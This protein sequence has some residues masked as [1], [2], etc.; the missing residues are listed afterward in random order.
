M[1]RLVWLLCCLAAILPGHAQTVTTVIPAHDY[2]QRSKAALGSAASDPTASEKQ[3]KAL[4]KERTDDPAVLFMLGRLVS[5]RG[6]QFKAG[7]KRR[8]LLAEARDYF[9]RAQKAG[10]SEPMIATALAQINPDG[11]ENRVTFSPDAKLNATIHD[12]E[13][14]F[15]QRNFTKAISL[16]QEALSL[17]PRHYLATLY[18]GDAYFASGDYVPAIKWF[19]KAAELDPDRETAHRY[20]GDA[21]MRTGK[22]D[23]AREEYLRA[24]I[25]E[26][27]NAYT[28]RALHN[29][30]QAASLNPAVPA[31]NLP[32]AEVRP[33]NDKKSEINL[34]ED[35][36]IFH[37][38]YAGARSKWQTENP[39]GG[40]SLTSPYRHTI[41]EEIAALRTLLVM[42]DEVKASQD[43]P[44]DDMTAALRKME[45]AIAELREIDDAG[46]LE[47]HVFFFR[48]GQEIAADYA[49]YRDANRQ[50]L[51]DYLATFY[52]G[53]R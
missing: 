29:Y 13:R 19:A 22:N 36:T 50:K 45:P 17:D 27:Y 23:L 53:L 28:W 51:R 39:P 21:L 10:S 42:V 4:L 35:F 38:L 33:G 2:E 40:D 16:Y 26:P 41:E 37:V 31:K 14:A 20:G 43:T 9:F 5:E 15:E 46:L 52:L 34:P 32:V 24:V 49:K 8:K 7:A 44:P 1:R 30:C 11:T 25:A 47:A 48:A 6:N 18:L 12:A 3:L